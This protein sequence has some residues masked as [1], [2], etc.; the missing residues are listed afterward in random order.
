MFLGEDGTELSKFAVVQGSEAPDEG[1]LSYSG[2]ANCYIVIRA[3]S[4][5]FKA[6]QGNSDTSVGDVAGV[7]VLWESFGTDVAPNKGD[8]IS[9]ASFANDYIS[10]ET[11]PEFREGNAVIATKDIDGRILWSWHIWLTDRPA[12]QVYRNNAGAMMDRNLGAISATPGDVGAL[13]LLYQWGRKDPFLGSSS[14][15]SNIKAKSTI[16]WSSFVESTSSTGTISYA[17]KHPTTFIS[18]ETTGNDSNQDWYY[19]GSSSTDQ[20]R[21]QSEKTIYDPCPP[22]YRVPDGG[23]NGVWSKAFGTSGSYPSFDSTNRG[24][25]FGKSDTNRLTDETTCWYPAAGEL[26]NR[27]GRLLYVGN[28]GRYR[29][30]SAIRDTHNYTHLLSIFSDGVVALGWG[31]RVTGYPVRCLRE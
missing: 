29:S 8:L 5:K 26:Q 13:G 20:T 2:S 12:D 28:N 24:F 31:D 7:E 1:D 16:E 18:N 14:I 22:G 9:H 10:F 19:T 4:Y 23:D 15:S 17:T 27:D 3:G 6:V 11:A 30:C 21:W 25:N